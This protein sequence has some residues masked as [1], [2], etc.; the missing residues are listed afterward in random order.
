MTRSLHESALAR[1]VLLSVLLFAAASTCDAVVIRDDVDDARY[2]V[3]AADFPALAD[4]PGE[5]HGVLVAPQW[6]LTAAHAVA[7][8]PD[9]DD[10]VI[11]GVPRAVERVVIHDGFRKPPDRLVDDGLNTWDWTLFVAALS[12]SDDI[13]LLKL[14]QP[15]ADVAP[16]AV[17]AADA[18]VGT[19]IEFL[20]KGASAT[21]ATGFDL[22]HGPHRTELRRAQNE[23]T[24]SHERWF[25]YVFD[26]PPAGLPLEG[27]S[28]SGDSGG[29]VLVQAGGVWQVAGLTAWTANHG[30]V[31]ANAGRYGQVS[32]NVRLRH[33]S[34]WIDAVMRGG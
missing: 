32:C 31:R 33:Y 4:L 25:C 2:R 8:Q 14:A 3:A 26:A 30:V 29:P 19:R 21:G 34:E 15:V 28:G 24:S 1:S 20:G 9:L 10:V 22:F 12:A 13:A 7:W 18:T 17:H 23:I 27:G 11:A 5:G 16:V 6:V